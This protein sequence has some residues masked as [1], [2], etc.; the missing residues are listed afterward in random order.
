MRRAVYEI[1]HE[2]IEKAEN[3]I[4]DP[5]RVSRSYQWIVSILVLQDELHRRNEEML[6]MDLTFSL[7]N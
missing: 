4:L 5:K 7:S 1:H 6:M 3:D 2:G